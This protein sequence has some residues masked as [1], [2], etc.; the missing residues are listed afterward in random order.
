MLGVSRWTIY[1][2][3]E[4]YGLQSMKEFSPLLSDEDLDG[5]L[6]DY[7]NRHGETIGQDK[8]TWLDTYVHVVYDYRETE[9]SLNISHLENPSMQ[10]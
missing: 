7:I 8:S 2:R 3:V 9:Y 1:R 5:L 4:K 10:P 6:T